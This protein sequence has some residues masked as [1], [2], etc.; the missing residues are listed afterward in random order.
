MEQK[1]LEMIQVTI[2]LHTDKFIFVWSYKN[3]NGRQ[4][5]FSG[6]K[7]ELLRRASATIY[8]LGYTRTVGDRRGL[9]CHPKTVRNYETGV[10]LEL[11]FWFW[12]VNVESSGILLQI[13]GEKTQY[14]KW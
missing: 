8:C 14:Q 1:L 10:T 6:A 5:S 3:G 4:N 2:W 13:G 9:S 11:F 7:S 12:P